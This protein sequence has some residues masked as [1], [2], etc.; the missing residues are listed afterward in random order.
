MRFIP[1]A[2]IPSQT[3]NIVL[4]GQDCALAVYWRQER[5][6]LD[7]TCN[8]QAIVV[9][10]ICENKVN[11]L[12]SEQLYFKGSLHFFDSEGD[13]PPHYEGLG[14]RRWALVFIAEGE[15]VPESL[16]F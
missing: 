3:L 12:Q 8:G 10:A 11:V 6:Y 5:L 9:G 7:L 16:R 4:D 2:A 15:T 14:D 13:R 1:L